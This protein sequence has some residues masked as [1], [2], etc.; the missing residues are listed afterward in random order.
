MAFTSAAVP[1]AWFE[2]VV[3]DP[4]TLRTD[5]PHSSQMPSLIFSMLSWNQRMTWHKTKPAWPGC[6]R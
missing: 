5:Q 2:T 4:E 3:V 6:S 1:E